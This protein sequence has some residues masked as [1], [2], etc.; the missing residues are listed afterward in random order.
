MKQDL[1][2]S[3]T[4]GDRLAAAHT[5][6]ELWA[7]MNKG[8]GKL[9][10]SSQVAGSKNHAFNLAVG[11]DKRF[12]DKWRAGVVLSYGQQG[13][14]M[15]AAK[16]DI[17]DVR[18]GVYG[19]YG[20]SDATNLDLYLTYG[21]QRNESKR[22]LA[23]LDLRA[24]SKYNSDLLSAGAKLSRKYPFMQRS[25]W[26]ISPYIGL[27]AAVYKLHGYT[28]NGA[29]VYDLHAG[30][31]SGQLLTAGIGF[32]IKRE[33]G[34]DGSYTVGV[35]YR[36]LL[37]GENSPITTTFAVDNTPFTMYG[38]GSGK[39]ILTLK[40]QGEAQVRK[41]L[42]V[43]GELLQDMGKDTRNLTAALNATWSF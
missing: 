31:Q 22:T 17:D 20:K 39:D 14:T 30:R 15:D 25:D 5:D 21:L 9:S 37:D 43:S 16:G 2:I 34:L 8:W 27:D 36:R 40:L 28:E 7:K 33:L 6:N 4:V 26:S 3:N 13:V 11:Q 18:L 29:G 19:R 41:N 38:N 42:T 12:S 32:D 35:G 1:F 24:D 23:N 10:G